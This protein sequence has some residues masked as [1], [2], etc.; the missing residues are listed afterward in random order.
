MAIYLA[1]LKD[2]TYLEHDKTALS[3]LSF[4]FASETSEADHSP[5]PNDKE[6]CQG[7]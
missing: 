5:S 7:L 2:V 6:K 1:L 4:C 3:K